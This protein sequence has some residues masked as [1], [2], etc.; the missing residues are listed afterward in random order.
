MLNVAA[1]LALGQYLPLALAWKTFQITCVP[2]T[3][4]K[5]FLDGLGGSVEEFCHWREAL[6]SG[7]R[8]TDAL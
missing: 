2:S 8:D 5:N 6:G 1:N 4:E 7:R 3:T